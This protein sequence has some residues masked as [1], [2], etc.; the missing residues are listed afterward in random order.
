M[1]RRQ[2]PALPAAARV[3]RVYRFRH[4][5]STAHEIPGVYRGPATIRLGAGTGVTIVAK[6]GDVIVLPAGT[7]HENLGSSPESHVIGGYPA[8]QSPDLLRGS[9]RE[10]AAAIE[11]I[12]HVPL[13]S[14]DPRH[15]ATGPLMGQWKIGPA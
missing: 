14:A 4:Y 1:N 6:P 7:G 8:G 5:H 3:A 12:A 10:R 2:L 9:A 13:P 15:G 11:R